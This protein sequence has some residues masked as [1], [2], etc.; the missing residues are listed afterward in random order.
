M[1]GDGSLCDGAGPVGERDV[2]AGLEAEDFACVL[3]LFLIEQDGG[4]GEV[5]GEEAVF[6]CGHGGVLCAC[7]GL[8]VGGLRCYRSAQAT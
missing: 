3:R 6:G 1:F 5:V 7:F 8:C 4:L 2:V